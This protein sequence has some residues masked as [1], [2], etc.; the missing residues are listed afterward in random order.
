VASATG[1]L[2]NVDST[3]DVRVNKATTELLVQYRKG[4]QNMMNTQ[5][6]VSAKLM[7]GSG[8]ANNPEGLLSDLIADVI[9]SAGSKILGGGK[10]CDMAL[11][12]NGGV[13]SILPKGKIMV[14]NIFEILPFE[15][16]VTVL[17]LSGVQLTEF[18]KE[19]AHIGGGVSGVQIV[20]DKKNFQLLRATI[21]G[22]PVDPDKSYTVATLNYLAEGNDGFKVL[23]EKSVPRINRD[24]VLLRDIFMDYVKQQTKEGKEIDAKLEGRFVYE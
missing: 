22:Q 23:A 1:K 9:R 15:N 11:M 18:L 21:G 7:K 12:N 14:S 24:D 6:G 2:L 3:Y 5:V 4:V 19:I 20:V 13:R 10:T 16:T 17:T 8:G